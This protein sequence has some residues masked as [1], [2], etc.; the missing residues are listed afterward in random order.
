M[1]KIQNGE[2]GS[3]LRTNS[4]F[5]ESFLNLFLKVTYFR[6]LYRIKVLE[7]CPKEWMDSYAGFKEI[8]RDAG[9]I[10]FPGDASFKG[11]PFPVDTREQIVR[12]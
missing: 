9:F 1:G 4:F 3:F 12:I 7:T 2:N 10:E 8:P 5:I 6:F 11:F